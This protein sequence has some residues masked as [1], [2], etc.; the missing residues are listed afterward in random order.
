[1]METV[2][3]I[4]WGVLWGVY[5][6]LDGYDL[7]A[8]ALMPVMAKSEEDR[9]KIYNS[10]GPF[11]DGNEVWL[12]TA[13]GVTFAA[14]PG[15]YAT[16]F[17]ALYSAL[18][19]VLF[20]LILRGA[21]LAMR[22]ETAN[23]RA[24]RFW[25]VLFYVGSFLAALLFGVFFANIF[26]GVPIDGEGVFHGNLFTLLNPYGLMGGLLFLVFFFTHGSI[27]LALKTDGDLQERA[28]RSALR[29][30]RVLLV[31]S[32]L[33]LVFSGILT[34][35]YDNYLANPV[36]FI[37]PVITVV[38]LVLTGIFVMKRDWYKSWW[39]SS[40]YILSATL[41]GV[42]G[43][44]PSLMPSSIDPA[45][46]RTIHNTASSPLTLKIMLGV[47]VVFVPIV[48]AYQAWIHKLFGGKVKGDRSAY[49]EGY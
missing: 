45:F 15:T 34:S 30:W 39:T 43:I 36:L 42:I 21:G 2:W 5:F 27:W 1:M 44:Y 31:I 18:M 35:L 24:R 3:F 12:I 13:G 49:H 6:L 32:V 22:E 48:I 14:F 16:M 26:K 41:F 7:G 20:A 17:S 9:K 25:D 37:I 47:V 28:T 29:F 23:P 40:I 8:G 46:S 4:L 33:F 38:S 10:I 19:L 11:W